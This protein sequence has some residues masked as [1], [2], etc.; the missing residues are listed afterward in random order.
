[1]SACGLRPLNT[2]RMFG[3]HRN[4]KKCTSRDRLI[5]RALNEMK[6]DG[7]TTHGDEQDVLF[8]GSDSVPTSGFSRCWSERVPQAEKM[9]GR[10]R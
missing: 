8:V 1:M 2:F 9:D 7:E 6:T 5:G 3:G 10:G 4:F